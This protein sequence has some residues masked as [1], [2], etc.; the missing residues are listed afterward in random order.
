MIDAKNRDIF[1]WNVDIA[2]FKEQIFHQAFG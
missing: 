2:Y 1:G